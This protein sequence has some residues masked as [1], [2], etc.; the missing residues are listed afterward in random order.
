MGLQ[1]L[2]VISQTGEEQTK[3]RGRPS[4]LYTVD[5]NTALDVVWRHRELRGYGGDILRHVVRGKQVGWDAPGFPGSTPRWLAF[6]FEP[7]AP[8]DDSTFRKLKF[9][10]LVA[11][12][13]EHD[14]RVE[15]DSRKLRWLRGLSKNPRKAKRVFR[16]MF[17]DYMFDVWWLAQVLFDPDTVVAVCP[18]TLTPIVRM[19]QPPP[20]RKAITSWLKEMREKGKERRKSETQE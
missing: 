4:G 18:T 10:A 8:R 15:H 2:G 17:D 11:E 6:G 19:G 1:E 9:Y 3:E 16:E 13:M 14:A 7:R 12:V 5:I 20:D